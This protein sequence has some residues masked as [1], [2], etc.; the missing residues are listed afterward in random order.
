M[1]ICEDRE[2]GRPKKAYGYSRRID[3]VPEGNY[4]VGQRANGLG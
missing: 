2:L 3:A 1:G 4:G